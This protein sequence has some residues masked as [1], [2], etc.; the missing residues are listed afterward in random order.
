MSSSVATSN[1]TDV[2]NSVKSNSDNS[3]VIMNFQNSDSTKDN[4]KT[5][6]I[7][8]TTSEANT[9]SPTTSEQ[10]HL[11]QK[12]QVVPFVY[13]HTPTKLNLPYASTN[14]TNTN[15]VIVNTV[16][17]PFVTNIGNKTQNLGLPATIVNNP[18]VI[19]GSS[20]KTQ[21][22]VIQKPS[23]TVQALPVMPVPVS[24]NYP[25]QKITG[26]YFTMLKPVQKPP[27]VSNNR[28]QVTSLKSTENFHIISNSTTGTTLNIQNQK[29]VFAP[30]P[31]VTTNRLPVTATTNSVQP[32]S[33]S[34]MP[35]VSKS[36]NSTKQKVLN[37]KITDGQLQADTHQT[38][39]NGD[40]NERK[41]I[42]CEDVINLDSLDKKDNNCDKTYELSI[43][44]DSGS[45]KNNM[46]ITISIPD[47]TDKKMVENKEKRDLPKFPK[48]GISILK[49]SFNFAE[50]RRQEKNSLI[51]SPVP[52]SITTIS[53]V[54][55]KEVKITSTDLEEEPVVIAEAKITPQRTERRRKSNVSFRRDYEDV[56]ITSS[57]WEAK[58]PRRNSF[59]TAEITFTKLSDSEGSNDNNIE[60]KDTAEDMIEI[61]V[62]KQAS[63]LNTN[64]ED[65]D[66]SKLLNWENGIGYLPGSDL[67]FQVNEFGLLEYITKD[68]Y[69][70]ILNKRIA[71]AKEKDAK[72]DSLQED[73]QCLNCGCY[74]IISDFINTRYCSF[75][76]QETA[77]KVAKEK[78]SK[79][80]KKKKKLY[81]KQAE[82]YNNDNKNEK[83]P[84][85]SEED[86]T[87]NENSQDKFNYPW[88]C[89][90]KGFSWSKYLDHIKAKS[91]PVKLFKDP[92]P[93]NRNG[94]RPG[95][96][97]EGVDPQ[98]PSYFCVLTVAEVIGYRLR[99]H[100]D[101]YPENYDFWVNA[102][103]IDIFPSG[104]CEKYGHVLHPPPGYTVDDF[105]W[106][107][108]L[109]QTKATAA[110]KH[111]F[112]NRAGNVR[113]YLNLLK[114]CITWLIVFRLFVQMGSEWE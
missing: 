30:M 69:Q 26:A 89:T 38:Q 14:K 52:N 5:V 34:F 13:I 59:D 81:K 31:K 80:K 110:P 104:W 113:K 107:T 36:I 54:N 56:E 74:G 37:L 20:V 106:N 2:V 11:T 4:N 39:G 100:F 77:N 79:L 46:G 72:K 64:G 33:I 67:K 8:I 49:K 23:G 94:F 98:H 19:F 28:V 16:A 12:A 84:S 18:G 22:I 10:T 41:S 83:E 76:C 101:G 57:T 86:D 95:M 91:A 99:L 43:V 102:D 87:S 112:V 32:N 63:D 48:H 3:S 35:L 75:D 88:T 47:D 109:K 65:H 82:L 78:E 103:S 1:A 62:I 93:Y 53:D 92:F 71:K 85:G 58:R 111:L 68:E 21:Q 66:V 51:I 55:T 6:D 45:T 50:H 42:I 73:V 24:T 90:K 29:Y 9:V 17:T 105:N 97:L 25:N 96:K 60:M 40:Q 108:Y 114:V 27:E 7:C 70:N 61:E 15:N 44:E